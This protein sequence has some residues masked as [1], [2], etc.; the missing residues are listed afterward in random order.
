MVDSGSEAKL[1][2]EGGQVRVNE[3][4]ETRR[5][6]RLSN[7]DRVAVAGDIATV[8]ALGNTAP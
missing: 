4:T 5:G 6:R 8:V 1:L 7:G 2:L 3:V